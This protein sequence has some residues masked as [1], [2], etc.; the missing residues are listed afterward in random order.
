MWLLIV[1]LILFTT[2]FI[3]RNVAM[4]LTAW[5]PYWKW[6]TNPEWIAQAVKISIYIIIWA[7]VI[8][9]SMCLAFVMLCVMG[10]KK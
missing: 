4:S 1:A 2:S 7:A 9:C 3:S 10:S 8:A 5:I 6:K